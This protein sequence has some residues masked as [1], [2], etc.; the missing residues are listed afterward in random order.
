MLCQ[1]DMEMGSAASG[2]AHDAGHEHRADAHHDSEA[3]D[4]A[5]GHDHQDSNDCA[6]ECECG[7]CVVTVVISDND[8]AS[9]AAY[10]GERP[11]M[12]DSNRSV[13]LNNIF[14]PPIS[15]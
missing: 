8:H 12:S 5:S 1:T 9:V 11:A 15:D 13:V 10:R 7:D 4:Q 2:H 3:H 14:R 6:S